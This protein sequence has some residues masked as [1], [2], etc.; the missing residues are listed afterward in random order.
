MDLPHVEQ[1]TLT[2]LS[3]LFFDAEIS[4]ILGTLVLGQCSVCPEEVIILV[5]GDWKTCW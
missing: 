2:R 5:S 1:A 4:N 3:Y